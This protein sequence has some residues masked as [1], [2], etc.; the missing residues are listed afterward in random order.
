LRRSADEARLVAKFSPAS[1]VRL[2]AHATAFYLKHT[3][4]VPFRVVHFATHTLV[5]EHTAAR[6]A[7]VLAGGQGES[8]FVGPEELANLRLNADLVV[9]SSC[10]SGGGVVVNGEG[11]QGLTAPLVQ[12]GARSVVATQW[13]IG[14]QAALK[15]VGALYRHLA[16]GHSVGEAL[17]LAKLDGMRRGAPPREWAAFMVTGDPSVRIPLRTPSGS[18]W[19]WLLAVAVGAA[20]VAAYSLRTRSRRSG[21]ER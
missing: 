17:R 14:D 21:E 8:G 13:E 19:G 2:G 10:R 12:A 4:L 16:Q 15:F 6:S 5:D 11:L 20:G 7:L 18:R 3:D 1:V 9:L